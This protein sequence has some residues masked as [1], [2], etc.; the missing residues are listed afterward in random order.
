M[1]QYDPTPNDE[2]ADGDMPDG[3]DARPG[4]GDLEEDFRAV[5][6]GFD[7]MHKSVP[8]P[9]VETDPG[10]EYADIERDAEM[11]ATRVDRRIEGGAAEVVDDDPQGLGLEMGL[12]F[13]AFE[14]T[15]DG[16]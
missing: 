6:M 9:L 4:V 8:D 11:E 14:V 12:D 10:A 13:D 1:T 7:E 5:T 3:M 2:P 16:E 15:Y